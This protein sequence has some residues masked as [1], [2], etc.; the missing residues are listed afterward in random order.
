ML[1]LPPIPHHPGQ[2]LEAVD[3]TV[4][5]DLVKHDPDDLIRLFNAT[6]AESTNT[7]LLRGED[8]P[9]YLPA[10]EQ[11]PRNRIYFAHGF[12]ASALHEIA[13]WTLAGARR[14]RLEDYGYW[15][16]PDGRN[17]A[18]QAEFERVERRPQA[19]EWALAIACDHP[20]RVSLDNLG[21][22]PT[23]PDAFRAKVHAELTRMH[24]NGFPPR[25]ERF[26]QV[27]CQA[28]GVT[29]RLPSG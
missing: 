4:K 8:E 13:H 22:A 26:R 10:D 14:R 20:F 16:Q 6:F 12:F 21:G 19:V 24:Y 3:T 7:V 15:Y 9:L 29:W 23:D 28:W 2:A 17:A 11:D 25:A 27:L 5:N 1:N 18:E